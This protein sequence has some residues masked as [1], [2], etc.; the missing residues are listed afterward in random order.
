MNRLDRLAHT[1]LAGVKNL[2]GLD[3]R[4]GS[5]FSSALFEAIEHF[6]KIP[7]EERA[8]QRHCK[9]L[10]QYMEYEVWHGKTDANALKNFSE[11]YD[12]IQDNEEAAKL[13]VDIYCFWE[14]G[15]HRGGALDYRTNHSGVP[16]AHIIVGLGQTIKNW[17]SYINS[18]ERGGLRAVKEDI[19]SRITSV[20]THELT[21]AVE[22]AYQ[23]AA[24]EKSTFYKDKRPVNYYKDNLVHM[25]YYPEIRAHASETAAK[26]WNIYHSEILDKDSGL[27]LQLGIEEA[28]PNIKHLTPENRKLFIKLVIDNLQKRKAE[29]FDVED[30]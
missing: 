11:A 23:S 21:H 16:Y 25:N 3:V 28:Y 13:F 6:G 20:F 15:R 26:I 1:H 27:S 12:V 29:Y 24:K 19:K 9:E 18:E 5:K 14:N 2:R 8:F 7:A 22:W 30:A 10:Q 4:L 17:V